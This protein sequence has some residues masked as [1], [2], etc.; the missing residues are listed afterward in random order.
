M[1]PHYSFNP[2]GSRTHFY[3]ECG[4]TSSFASD[5][6]GFTLVEFI[7]VILLLSVLS[8]IVVSNSNNAGLEAEVAGAT[9]VLK[10]HLR[11]AQTKAMNSNLSWGLNFSG[12]A[13]TLQDSNGVTAILPGDPPQGM[14]VTASSNPIL[15]ENRW[16]S[17]GSTTITVTV[18]KNGVSRTITVTKN[19]GFIP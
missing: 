3:P 6:K 11:Y 5:K 12:S 7:A 10:N 4:H 2:K 9:E 19:T 13:Y 15:F 18:S 8:L 17:P 14:T 16:G 1:T